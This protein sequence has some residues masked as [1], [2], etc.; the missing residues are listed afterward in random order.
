MSNFFGEYIEQFK[1]IR[2]LVASN[3]SDLKV[4]EEVHIII[5]S[6]LIVALFRSINE[7][8]MKECPPFF[9]FQN[10][11]EQVVTNIGQEEFKDNS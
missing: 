3:R 1:I 10:S 6:R 2:I 11:V 8:T 7:V 9:H 5:F 4:E